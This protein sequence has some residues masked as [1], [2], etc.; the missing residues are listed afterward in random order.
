MGIIH[1]NV[2]GLWNILYMFV[3]VTKMC[4]HM[5]KLVC[6]LYVCVNTYEARNRCSDFIL[7]EFTLFF[8]RQS[9]AEP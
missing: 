6:M 2:G 4:F 3:Y 1:S 8:L 5:S 9:F 7:L